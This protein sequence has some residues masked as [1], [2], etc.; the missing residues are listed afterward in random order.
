M[1]NMR[2]RQ[3]GTAKL[4]TTTGLEGVLPGWLRPVARER[5]EHRLVQIG[6]NSGIPF[7]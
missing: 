6:I 5:E 3:Q 1:R 4:S 2:T 7:L